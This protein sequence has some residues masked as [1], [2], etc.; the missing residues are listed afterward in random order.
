MEQQQAE[1]L[2][3]EFLA[4]EMSFKQIAAAYPRFLLQIMTT[5]LICVAVST[6]LYAA[7][8]FPFMIDCYEQVHGVYRFHSNECPTLYQIGTH[9]VWM[10]PHLEVV[11]PFFY[12]LNTGGTQFKKKMMWFTVLWQFVVIGIYYL[13]PIDGIQNGTSVSMVLCQLV[14]GLVLALVFA[15]EFGLERRQTAKIVFYPFFVSIIARLLFISV[16]NSLITAGWEMQLL[17]RL[18]IL[19]VVLEAVFLLFRISMTVLGITHVPY[20]YRYLF[21]FIASPIFVLAFLGRALVSAVNDLTLMII[22]SVLINIVEIIVRLTHTRRDWLATVLVSYICCARDPSLDVENSSRMSVENMRKN[23]K[24][25]PSY[26]QYVTSPWDR[27]RIIF[28]LRSQIICTELVAEHWAILFAP[29]VVNLVSQVWNGTSQSL[30]TI[31][32]SI[33]TQSLLEHLT[34][35]VCVMFEVKH[36]RINVLQCW[37]VQWGSVKTNQ[38]KWKSLGALVLFMVSFSTVTLAVFVFWYEFFISGSIS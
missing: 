2:E 34:D 30:E 36:Q 24:R 22:L 29:I 21:T 23:A 37:F 13:D 26:H 17:T 4:P 14:T 1:Q 31:L 8:Y 20:H 19:P 27:Q 11:M 35:F 16:L 5:T 6:I 18:V 28:Q 12:I 38:E 32:V 15:K 25:A 3:E 9:I 10:A 7:F 33:I